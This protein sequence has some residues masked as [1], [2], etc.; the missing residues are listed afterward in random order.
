[1][2]KTQ[3]PALDELLRRLA[4]APA[5]EVPSRIRPGVVLVDRLEVQYQLGA[6]GMGRVYAAFD[7][8]RQ[9]EVAVKV[10]GRL[11]PHSIVQLKREF[12]SV[13]ELVHPNLVRCHELFSDG[14]EWFFTMDLVDG[15]TLPAFL[16]EAAGD[17][18]WDALRQVLRQLAIALEGLHDAGL[19]HGDL[20]P[21][22]FLIRKSDHQVVLMDFGLARPIGLAA[23]RAVGGTPG[24]MAP[25]Q[26]LGETL[27]EAVDWYAFGVV[28][29][30]ALAG[31]MPEGGPA[32]ERLAQAP[33][34][35]A[36][37]CLDLLQPQP[38]DRPTGHEVLRRI[39]RPAE[40]P[41][42]SSAPAAPRPILIGREE[43]LAQL[44]RAYQAALSGRPSVAWVLGP[45]GI[46][47]TSLATTFLNGVRDRGALVLGGSCRERESMP[48]KAVDGLVDDLVRVL[49]AL[50]STE[51]A[52]LLPAHLA[53]LTVLFP[54]LRE[55]AVVARAAGVEVGSPDQT[56][57]RLRAIA[58]FG[59]VLANLRRRAPLVVW[60]DDLQWSDAE[61]AL[62]LG[63]VLGGAEPVPLL[64]LGG[65]RTGHP[66][67]PARS[68]RPHSAP[69]PPPGPMPEALLGD[70][71]LAIPPPAEIKLAPLGSDAAERLALELL[72]SGG[73]GTPVTARD[74]AQETDGHPLFITELA[75]AAGQADGRSR[76][77][78]PWTL[79][80]LVVRRVAALPPAARRLLEMAA[81]AGAPL[82]RSVLRK[83][84]EVGFVEAEASVDLLRANRLVRTQGPR[85]EDAVD[86]HHDRIREIVVHWMG[87][88]HRKRCH[89]ALA[90]VLEGRTESQPDFVATHFEAAGELAR[91]SRHW[92]LAADQAARALAFDHAAELYEKAVLHAH[93]EPGALREIG[94]RRAEAL[95][96]A[97]KG[98]ASADVYLAIAGGC[99]RDEAVELRR[100]AAE[101]LFLS[102]HVDRGLGLMEEVLR[103]IGLRGTRS[104]SRGLL[105]FAAGRLRV[106]ARGLRHV[107]RT[108]RELSREELVRLDASWTIAC[109]LGGVDFIR[110]ADFQNEHLLLALRAGEPRRLLRALS[111]EASYSATPGLGSQR[112]TARLLAVADEL[113]KTSGDEMALAL[114]AVARGVAAYLQGRLE[115]ACVSLDGVIESLARRGAG[116]VLETLTAQRF[117]I[118]SLFFLGR[119]KRLGEL[120]PPLLA[121][122]EGTGN[123]YATLVYRTGYG[124]AVW[125]ARNDVRE[126]S[127]QLQRARDEWGGGGFQLSH[128]NML[129]GETYLDLYTGDEERALARLREQWDGV[130]EAQLL[131]IAVIR[132][133]LLQLRS[134][135]AAAAADRADARGLRARAAELRRTAR[136]DVKGLRRER[137]ARA[138][139]WAEL[140]D[141]SLA[142]SDRDEA[143]TRRRLDRAIEGFERQGMQLFAAAARVRLGEL[144]RGTGGA[145]MAR[146]GEEAFARE[147]VANPARMV[148]MLAP[149]FGSTPAW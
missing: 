65:C 11:T 42:G 44:E 110:A 25:E 59:E 67:A 85:E 147:R 62:L 131:H 50:P 66:G 27:T 145:A 142:W 32:A 24:Y 141:A 54:A 74:I 115:E 90:R 58:A 38:A 124:A 102:G 49:D 37:L 123:I 55:A 94:I 70:R 48:Y 16:K 20:K 149:G 56:L 61:S 10:L 1:V 113:A 88:T 45:S 82:P 3:D 148:A 41:R 120:V 2:G 146:A 129:I 36:R 143:A 133:Q 31:E 19:L 134:A 138:A 60:V 98:P 75:H 95:A 47:K 128:L 64:F 87:E 132:A 80:D 17:P 29:H 18:P 108:E 13:A 107:V 84:Q 135:C 15:F 8:A 68:A 111:V 140:V 116:A 46:G 139:P 79:Q 122:A 119:L 28:L 121:D 126:A 52:S 6:G 81:L 103:A 117:L 23:L 127:R 99:A 125:L 118:A 78:A 144:A 40:A 12:R 114:L 93:L 92:L 77:D 83:A 101:Q 39:G 34:D 96:R 136:A 71:N 30:R 130:R 63:P 86:V 137:V 4:E 106:R 5:C 9:Q 7:R 69:T 89:L 26:R 105:S 53:E 109:T 73:P 21:S 51:A 57:V 35:L 104:G 33:E 76:G 22:N 14:V 112:R 91:A 72:P 97:G 43:E 100:R